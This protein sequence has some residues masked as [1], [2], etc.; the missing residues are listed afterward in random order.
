MKFSN[1]VSLIQRIRDLGQD[2]Q[3]SFVTPIVSSMLASL[4]TSPGGSECCSRISFASDCEG[5]AANNGLRDALS[6]NYEF[7]MRSGK[8]GATYTKLTRLATHAEVDRCN[9]I[10]NDLFFSQLSGFNECV[11]G[12]LAKVVGELHDNVASHANGAGFSC[13]QVY[14]QNGGKRIQFAIAD[15]GQGMLRN[16]QRI[17]P[18]LQSHQEAVNWCFQRGNTT[19]R[20]VEDPWAQRLPE[21]AVC[22]PF[23]SAQ[24]YSELENHHVGE[25]LWKLAELVRGL[26]GGLWILSG[27]GQFRYENGQEWN[28]TCPIQ[29]HGAAIEFELVVPHDNRPTPEQQAGIEALAGRIGL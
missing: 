17:K 2:A 22:N 28:D 1:A 11:V 27:D 15:A 21:D 8:Q 25:G 3:V 24:R 5:Y 13:A 10:V 19:A 29:W 7:P 14:D 26:R 12:E 6:G 20:R 16:V 23:P 9:E 4:A 18:A